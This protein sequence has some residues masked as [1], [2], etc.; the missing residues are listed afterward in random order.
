[1]LLTNSFIF[2]EIKAEVDALPSKLNFKIG[3]A[4]KILGV[5]PHVL[6][7]WEEEFVLLNPKKFSNNQ[8]LY[9]RKDIELLF[10]IKTLLYQEKLKI[11]GVRKHLSQFYHQFKEEKVKQVKAINPQSHTMKKEVKSLLDD[12]SSLKSQLNDDGFI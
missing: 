6:R 1:M 4:A 7:Y 10:L 11:Q 3:E 8:R 2:E 12:I 9:F 5:E